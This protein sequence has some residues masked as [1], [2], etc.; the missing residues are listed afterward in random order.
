MAASRFIYFDLGNVLVNFDHHRGARQMAEVAGIA[1]QVVWE[2]VFESDL[3]LEYERGAI[4]TREFFE[5]FC[6]RTGTRPDYEA[7]LLAAADIFEV[8]ESI[9]PL[10]M[11]LRERHHRL[12]I[13][14]NTNESHWEFISDGRFPIV[15]DFFE[16]YA[17]SYE[18][19]SAKPDLAAYKIAAEL[20]GVAPAEIFFT[21]DRLDNVEA[22]RRAGF[23][24]VQFVGV[25]TL[26]EALRSRGTLN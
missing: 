15:Q 24:A 5:A 12:G 19:R 20:A 26:R 9:I 8:N 25:E 18:M 21:D 6:A 14:S 22:A 17:L 11:E 23:D 7:L 4:T 13:L 16:R 10:L 3:Q 2:V 1:E